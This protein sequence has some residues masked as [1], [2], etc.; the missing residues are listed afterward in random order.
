MKQNN[1]LQYIAPVGIALLI[2]LMVIVSVQL[3]GQFIKLASGY[4][5]G[6]SRIAP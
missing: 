1:P 6:I 2:A 3:A 4:A 5:V